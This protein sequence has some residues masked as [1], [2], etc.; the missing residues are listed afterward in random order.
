MI[1]DSEYSSGTYYFYNVDNPYTTEDA[2]AMVAN[3]C[4]LVAHD[5]GLISYLNYVEGSESDIY[6]FN[7][8]DDNSTIKYASIVSP[9]SITAGGDTIAIPAT[10]GQVGVIEDIDEERMAYVVKFDELPTT[11]KINFKANLK[12]V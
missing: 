5:G 12:E 11:R 6:L 9:S 7:N 10:V 8:N 3:S 1:A 2:H 4:P